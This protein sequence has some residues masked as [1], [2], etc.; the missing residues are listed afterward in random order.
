MRYKAT[1]S[2]GFASGY[3]LG[4]KAGRAR[5]DSIV[6][7]ART[8]AENP[9]VQGAAGVLQAQLTRT[10]QSARRLVTH[11]VTDAISGKRG[12]TSR[13]GGGGHPAPYPGADAPASTNGSS[14][15]VGQHRR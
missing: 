13:A 9:A 1:F 11:T 7:S 14:A 10:L 2:V 6:R 12:A 15:D 5:Y 3:L 8:L 4:A